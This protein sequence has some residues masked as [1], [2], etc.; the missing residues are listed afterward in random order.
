MI[1]RLK[2]K[3]LTWEGEV[4]DVFLEEVTAKVSLKDQ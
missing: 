4:E 2:E 1:L 3:H